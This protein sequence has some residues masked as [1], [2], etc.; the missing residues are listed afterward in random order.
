[1]TPDQLKLLKAISK[2]QSYN[3]TNSDSRR[4][5]RYLKSQGYLETFSDGGDVWGCG[6]SEFCKITELGRAFLADSRRAY[7]KQIVAYSITTAIAIAG[8]VNSVL[9]RLG[10]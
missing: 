5:I 8:L 7:V 2:V 4:V 3:Y 9:A 1:M 6:G 10:L